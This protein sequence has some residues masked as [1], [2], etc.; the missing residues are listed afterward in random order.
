MADDYDDLRDETNYDLVTRLIKFSR[1]IKT[2]PMQPDMFAYMLEIH[3]EIARRQAG[4]A[5][6]PVVNKPIDTHEVEDLA[7]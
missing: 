5:D 6:I 3:A 4:T 7:F 2:L 1:A